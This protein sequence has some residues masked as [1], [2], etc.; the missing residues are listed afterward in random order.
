MSDAYSPFV[1]FTYTVLDLDG[2][3]QKKSWMLNLSYIV[4][5]E[6]G[7]DN[8]LKINMAND[9]IV[10]IELGRDYDASKLLD[11]L[12]DMSAEGLDYNVYKINSFEKKY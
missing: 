2:H 11:E 5:I 3:P 6:S 1:K 8:D 10:T 7:N 12:L 9:Q 4:S